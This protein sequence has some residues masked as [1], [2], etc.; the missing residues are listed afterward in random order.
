MVELPEPFATP[1]VLVARQAT[2]ALRGYVYQIYA[3][4]L[5]W[6]DLT[7]N[8]LLVLE[9]LEQVGDRKWATSVQE[10]IAD[11]GPKTRYLPF[12]EGER[13]SDQPW[14]WRD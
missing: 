11:G 6:L 1:P 4:A 14:R 12:V 10:W 5:A 9:A 13:P 2:E 7:E 8:N 3:S